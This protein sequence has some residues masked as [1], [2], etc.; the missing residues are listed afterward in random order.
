MKRSK[1]L[2]SMGQLQTAILEIV[3]ELGEAT[4]QQVRDRLADQ[5]TLAYTTVLSAMQK[6]EKAGWL[7][8]RHEGRAYVYLPRHSRHE[9]GRSA[10]KQFVRRVFAGDQ[11]A[12][13]K[14]LLDDEELSSEDL[15]E[16][17]R[18]IDRARKE[19]KDG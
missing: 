13:F 9:A 12:L 4:V 3:W 2:G 19:R 6:L 16:I 5:K 18:M 14:H 8:H 10:L 17:Q 11:L 1:P 7:K 15:T